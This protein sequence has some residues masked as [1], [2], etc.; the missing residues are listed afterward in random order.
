M[1]ITA[2]FFTIEPIVRGYP[3]VKNFK[4]TIRNDDTVYDVLRTESPSVNF[5]FSIVTA[6][7]DVGKFDLT[8]LI[9]FINLY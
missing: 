3:E 2:T 8:L 9:N 4:I 6:N 7:N 5:N 1:K